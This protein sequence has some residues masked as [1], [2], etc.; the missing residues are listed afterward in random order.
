MILV[1]R[2]KTGDLEKIFKSGISSSFSKLLRNLCWFICSIHRAWVQLEIVKLL[3]ALGEFGKGNFQHFSLLNN[4]N[5]R[6]MCRF[7]QLF[8]LVSAFGTCSRSP[9]IQKEPPA[10]LVSIYSPLE[11]SPDPVK[12]PQL[13]RGQTAFPPEP[14]R[15][16]DLHLILQVGHP[17][18]RLLSLGANQWT[19]RELIQHLNQTNLCLLSSCHF[20]SVGMELL[21]FSWS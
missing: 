5:K 12:P 9:G 4:Q 18:A 1:W 21:S 8:L 16:L 7:L 13:K 10:P 17:A 11:C 20:G 14:I 19:L 3:I 6:K 2:A 15:R